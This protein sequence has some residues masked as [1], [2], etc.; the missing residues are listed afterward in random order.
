MGAF[1]TLHTPINCTNCAHSFDIRVQFKFGEVWQ[2]QYYLK[3]K[4]KCRSND[5]RFSGHFKVEVYGIAE[6]V[7]CP[8]CEYANSEEYDILIEDNVIRKIEVIKDIRKYEEDPEGN[9]YTFNKCT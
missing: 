6:N 1:N 5:N 4:I 9:F 3:N 2:Y 7:K 8:Y